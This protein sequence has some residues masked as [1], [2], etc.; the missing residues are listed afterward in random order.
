MATRPV[1][2]DR[3]PRPA[4]HASTGHCSAP[5]RA[6]WSRASKPNSRAPR[7]AKGPSRP[8]MYLGTPRAGLLPP[9]PNLAWILRETRCDTGLEWR[10]CRS[11]KE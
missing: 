8:V 7:S 4:H 11:C 10:K 2:G 3:S 5:R 1:L 9:A 6:N